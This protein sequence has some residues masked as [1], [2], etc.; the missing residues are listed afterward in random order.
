MNTQ[1]LKSIIASKFSSAPTDIMENIFRVDAEFKH[2]TFARYYFDCT[3]SFLAENFDL[4]AYQQTL[5]ADDYYKSN[6]P[7]QWNFYLYFVTD[8]DTLSADT[9]SRIE[10]DKNFSRKL[11]TDE[12]GLIKL[13]EVQEKLKLDSSKH[14]DNSLLSVWK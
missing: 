11:I 7:L 12:L 5:M 10:S 4:L 8:V 14:F 1:E 6:G 3:N 9:R 2:R 13:F